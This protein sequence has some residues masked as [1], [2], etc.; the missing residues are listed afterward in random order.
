MK[1]LLKTYKAQLLGII[2]L[3]ISTTLLFGTLC[4]LSPHFGDAPIVP[5]WKQLLIVL[6]YDTIVILSLVLLVNALGFLTNSR[7]SREL[8]DNIKIGFKNKQE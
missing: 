1:H 4:Y 6:K 2:L 5:Y 7:E 8:M 3:I